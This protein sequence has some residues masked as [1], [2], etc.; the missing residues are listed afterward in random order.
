M[1]RGNS[2]NLRNFPSVSL[3]GRGGLETLLCLGVS[4]DEVV[5]VLA[6]AR[7]FE[8]VSKCR[9]CELNIDHVGATL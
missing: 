8:L 9:A 2:Q 1:R 6:V 4:N 3:G 7:E 5:C